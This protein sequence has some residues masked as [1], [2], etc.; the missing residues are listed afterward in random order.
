MWYARKSANAV[1]PAPGQDDCA[2]GLL[3]NLRG[4]IYMGSSATD[5]L[6]SGNTKRTHPHTHTHTHTSSHTEPGEAEPSSRWSRSP[7]LWSRPWRRRA[8]P[9]APSYSCP[10]RADARRRLFISAVREPRGSAG[11]PWT[12]RGW[13]VGRIVLCG[14]TDDDAAAQRRL[15]EELAPRLIVRDGTLALGDAPRPAEAPAPASAGRGAGAGAARRGAGAGAQRRRAGA[16][17]ISGRGARAGGG[18]GAG[19]RGA[20]GTAAP[21]EPPVEAPPAAKALR[22]L[23]GD[24]HVPER[25]LR[26]HRRR[27]RRARRRGQRLR[28]GQK[29]TRTSTR[30]PRRSWCGARRPPRRWPSS[31]LMCAA[32]RARARPRPSTARTSRTTATTAASGRASSRRRRPRRSGRPLVSARA[33]CRTLPPARLRHV[34][35]R[36]AGASATGKP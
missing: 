34:A 11:R 10:L 12:A 19:A 24:G 3:Q 35:R 8:R 15:C 2:R 22:A 21:A 33:A 18:A 36:R 31:P 1:N 17:S 16:R 4:A 25:P 29:N 30:R 7:W 28:F 27:R 14:I 13:N 23:Q 20:R 26:R 5:N 9:G 6:W 32:S